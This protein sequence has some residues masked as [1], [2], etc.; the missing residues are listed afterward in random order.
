MLR[1]KDE[2]LSVGYLKATKSNAEKELARAEESLI[3]A[4]CDVA[5]WRLII[6]ECNKELAKKVVNGMRK[7]NVKVEVLIVKLTL[8]FITFLVLL[9][10]VAGCQTVKGVAGDTGWI[11]TKMSENIVVEQERSK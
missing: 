11:L 7:A 8:A 9:T 4:R 1:K 5:A 3:D 2:K 6:F 10:I